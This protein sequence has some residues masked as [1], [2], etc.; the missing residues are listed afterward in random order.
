MKITLKEGSKQPERQ[1]TDFW[2]QH[3]EN[4]TGKLKKCRNI[5][6]KGNRKSST[7]GEKCMTFYE[8]VRELEYAAMKKKALAV[9]ELLGREKST[10][11]ELN[12]LWKSSYISRTSR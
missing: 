12:Q 11:G 6:G 5:S 3:L 9:E 1:T 2:S 10:T 4:Q 7:S 8:E